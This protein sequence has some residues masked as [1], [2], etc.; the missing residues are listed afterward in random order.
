MRILHRD[1][2]GL[3]SV[4]QPVLVFQS[5]AFHTM[6]SE[7]NAVAQKFGNGCVIRWPDLVENASQ[8]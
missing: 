2:S 4:A 3:V 6:T 8:N 5:I 1:R 7:L